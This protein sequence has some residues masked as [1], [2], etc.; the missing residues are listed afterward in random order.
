MYEFFAAKEKQKF[1]S[2]IASPSGWDNNKSD[3]VIRL[4]IAPTILLAS[5]VL[6]IFASERHK[7]FP[8]HKNEINAIVN[9]ISRIYYASIS[10]PT[11]IS[12]LYTAGISRSALINHL[13]NAPS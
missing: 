11:L 3:R 6:M 5:Y 8:E 10:I 7:V 12:S 4:I 13:C 2:L 1:K 9:Q